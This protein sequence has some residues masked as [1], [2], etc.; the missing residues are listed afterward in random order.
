MK[1][2]LLGATGAA[3]TL[4]SCTTTGSIDS[5]IQQSLPQICNAADIG[6][7]AYAPLIASGAVPGSRARKVEVAYS[8]IQAYCSNP[9]GQTL[10]STLIAAT[11]AYVVITT[12]LREAKN[13]EG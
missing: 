4:S 6:Y 13:V 3:L 8:Q 1:T 2:L 11:T 9:S 12:A 7:A 10:A 5:A